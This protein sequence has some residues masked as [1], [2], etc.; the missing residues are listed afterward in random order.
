MKV[1]DIQTEPM[2]SVGRVCVI[3]SPPKGQRWDWLLA[4][5][6]ELGVDWIR[7]C[8]YERTVRQGN[9]KGFCERAG[10]IAISSAKQCKRLYMPRIDTPAT[11]CECIEA[12]QREYPTAKL[13][14]LSLSEDTVALSGMSID[15]DREDII[16]F[17]GPEGGF[18][19]EEEIEIKGYGAISVSLTSTVLRT[20]TAVVTATALLCCKRNV[21]G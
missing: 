12:A 11:L 15:F 19:H 10:N 13:L 5:S 16:V 20:E 8:L 17:V 2:R 14:L 18:T 6:I 7:P 21:D 9:A 1:D 3:T 4:K